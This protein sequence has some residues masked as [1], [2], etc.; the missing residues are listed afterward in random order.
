MDSFQDNS[1]DLFDYGIMEDA[2]SADFYWANQSACMEINVSPLG[3]VSTEKGCKRKR[4][5]NETSSRAG[6]KACR[7][8]VRREKIN[9]R[10]FDLSSVLDPGRPVK[11][12]KSAILSDA[13]RVLNQLR[14]EA[15][16]LRQKNERL[17]EHIK[18]LKTEKTELREEKLVLKAEK[19][20]M[21]QQVKSMT[22]VPAGFAPTPATYHPLRNKMMAFPNYSGFPMWHWI[23]PA[24][25]DTSQDHVLRPPVA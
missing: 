13:I 18:S 14:T 17:Q 19:D 20:K 11:S 4:E 12:D 5:Q 23:P 22:V 7:E 16:E 8:K 2:T 3:D 21:E 6:N 25:T 10:F 24:V 9:D 15:Q 1:W